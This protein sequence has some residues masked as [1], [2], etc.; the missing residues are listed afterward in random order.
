MKV[1]QVAK[2]NLYGTVYTDNPNGKTLT[3]PDT[4]IPFD[5]ISDIKEKKSAPALTV[6]A[7][8]VPVA[9]LVILAFNTNPIESFEWNL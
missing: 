2:E 3:A 1:L 8:V 7:I 4:I 9:L 5:Q 6:A